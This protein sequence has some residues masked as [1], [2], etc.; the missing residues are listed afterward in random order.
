MIISIQ[1]KYTLKVDDFQFRCSIGKNG[2]KKNKKEGDRS[3]P[4]GIFRLSKVY[5]RSDRIKKFNCEIKKI[6]IHKYMGWC[7]DPKSKF[8]NKLINTR[9]KIKH[10]KLFRSDN[11]YNYLIELDYNRK[12]IIP[13][14]GSAIFLHITKNYNPTAGCVAISTN[15]M[16]ILLKLIKKKTFI[17]I[18]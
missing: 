9:H 16:R 15:D 6:K 4:K 3:T 8:Y 5:Y 2:I 18:T 17:Q 7:D 13:F 12:K 10:E 11:K 14:R 1:N